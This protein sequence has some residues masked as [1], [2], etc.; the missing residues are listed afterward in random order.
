MS[1]LAEKGDE[2]QIGVMLVD[3]HDL[4]RSGLAAMLGRESDITVVGQS[5]SGRAGV[6]LGQELRPQVVLM[7]LSMP[8]LSGI[9]AT[10]EIL[11]STP[12][13]RVLVLSAV[14]EDGD[15][16][17]A[18]LAGAC[19]FLLKD[20]PVAD[21]ANAVRAASVGESWLAPR[22]ASAVLERLRRDHVEP[23][24]SPAPGDILS[25]RELDILR[26]VARGLG[27]AEIATELHISPRTAKNHLSS[28]LAKLGV[29]NRVQAAIYAVRHR[30]D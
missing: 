27:N 14:S 12:D 24:G 21:I 23:I 9:D 18:V 2:K 7:D 1:G 3:D 26:L 11:A 10:R 29:D 8:D 15:V 5:S 4:F 22:A 19:G 6:R 20:A 30:L 16:E 13:T 28:V 25:P 17:A